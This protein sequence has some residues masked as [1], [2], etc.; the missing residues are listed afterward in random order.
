MSLIVFGK[1]GARVRNRASSV[2]LGLIR[3]DFERLLKATQEGGGLHYR[4]YANNALNRAIVRPGRP[5]LSVYFKV[6]LTL[7]SLRSTQ[8]CKTVGC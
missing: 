2:Q 7:E 1:I 3:K 5:G 4:D 8:S 6:E